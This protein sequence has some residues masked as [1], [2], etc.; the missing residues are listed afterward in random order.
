MNVCLCVLITETVKIVIAFFKSGR[1]VTTI[2]ALGSRHGKTCLYLK[3]CNLWYLVLSCF[4]VAC[5]AVSSV[6]FQLGNEKQKQICMRP[7]NTGK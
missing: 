5:M 6:F 7:K 4:L 2:K 1:K 3:S